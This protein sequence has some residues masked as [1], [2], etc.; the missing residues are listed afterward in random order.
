MACGQN[1]ATFITV[2]TLIYTARNDIA[3]LNFFS[4]IY[5]FGIINTSA[6]VGIPTTVRLFSDVRGALQRIEMFLTATDNS[7]NKSLQSAKNWIKVKLDDLPK[8]SKRSHIPFVNLNDVTCQIPSA[9]GPSQFFESK[10]EGSSVLKDI[11]LEVACPELVLICG[12]VG[13]GKS[14]LLQTILGELLVTNGSVNYSGQLAYVSDSPWVFPGTIRENIVF[15]LPYNESK[16]NKII[17]ACQ[18]GK[19]FDNFPDHDLTRIGE[20]SATLSGGQR[21]RIALARAVYS[22]ADIYLLDDPLSSLDINVAENLFRLVIHFSFMAM[23]KRFWLLIRQL[24]V[25][26]LFNFIIFGKVEIIGILIR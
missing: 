23:C 18:L 12:G 22:E 26:F 17:K 6:A 24:T 16:Y 10:T 14:S 1:L 4:M 13:T 11:N 25:T 20:N 15:G 9:C 19:D 8:E 21:T 2:C 7:S 3:Y 5:L